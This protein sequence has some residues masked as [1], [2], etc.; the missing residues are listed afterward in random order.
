V[1]RHRNIPL[2]L[3]PALCPGGLWVRIYSDAGE[4]LTDHAIVDPTDGELDGELAHAWRYLVAYDG[5][6]GAL[7]YMAVADEDGGAD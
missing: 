5:D 6:T 1:I 3:A 7:V 4:L 2:E